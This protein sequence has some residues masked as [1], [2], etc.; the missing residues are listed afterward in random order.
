MPELSSLV[1]K[2]RMAFTALRLAAP[3]L[4]ALAEEG[5]QTP[6]P[7]QAQAIPPALQG[8]DLLGCAQTGT[9]KT[10]AFALPIIQR[11]KLAGELG[12]GTPK[13]PAKRAAPGRPHALILAPTREL[14]VQIDQSLTTYGRHAGVRTAVIF[15][16]VGQNPQVKALQ[17]GVDIVVATPGRLLDL[18]QQRHLSL[19][20]VHIL[21]LD[22]AD[23]MLDM[24]F[25]KPIR[26]IAGMVAKER[27]TMLFSATMPKEIQHLA[28]ALLRDP[29]KVAVTPVASAA[30]MIEQRVHPVPKDLKQPLLERLLEDD[31]LESVVVF[32][33]TKHGADRVM[34]RLMRAKVNAAAIHGNKNQNQRQR[35]LDGFKAGTVRVLVATDVASRG[36]DVDDVSHVINYDIPIDPESYVHRIGRTGRAGKTGIAI[37]FCEPGDRGALKAIEKLIGKPVPQVAIPQ[38]LQALSKLP[39]EPR[40]EAPARGGRSG[41][42]GKP[43]QGGRGGKP[44]PKAGGGAD[45]SKGRGPAHGRGG[46]HAKASRGQSSGTGPAPVSWGDAGGRVAHPAQGG[47]AATP[48]FRSI[49]GMNRRPAR[50]R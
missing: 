29:V 37:S 50:G 39:D 8:R 43:S 28:D 16:G 14:A 25:I 36:I 2:K 21:V 38:D 33:R 18:I 31:S 11:L 49:G 22:E 27:Q 13:H 41:R 46:A 23:R 42:G 15:G 24:G 7:I 44:A 9:G 20:D 45:E 1:R 5:Y 47:R 32:T 34:K 4:K 26:Q 3:I 30:P 40:A 48:A 6:T 19:A 10:A 17:S 12:E 35:A